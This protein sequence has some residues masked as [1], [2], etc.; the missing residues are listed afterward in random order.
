MKIPDAKDALD[1]EWEKL[2]KIP[3]WNWEN[4]KSK[5]DVILEAQKE[6]KKV[7]FATLMDICHLKNAEL[8]QKHQKYKGRIVLRG[9]IVKDGSGENE[10]FTEQGSSA[11]QAIA[12]RVMD[13]TARLPDCAGQAVDAMS[14]FSQVKLEDDPRLLKNPKSEWSDVWIRL[15]RHKW[16]KSFDM[17][18]RAATMSSL[19]QTSYAVP[20]LF[21]FLSNVI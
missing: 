21:H 5:K 15:P 1:E 16:P 19:S 12:A 6:K 11:S 14:A 13:V 20:R 8:E 2:E 18:V 4:M 17:S 9:D 7:H 3:A 10:V